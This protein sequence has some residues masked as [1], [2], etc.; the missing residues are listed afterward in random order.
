[1]VEHGGT[2]VESTDTVRGF[3]TIYRSNPVCKEGEL[4]VADWIVPVFSLLGD[5]DAGF[6]SLRLYEFMLAM[7]DEDRQSG[8][9][10]LVKMLVS[11]YVWM[12]C[13][14][15]L[16][17]EFNAQNA[18]L[19][20]DASAGRVWVCVRDMADVFQDL[21]IRA[22]DASV[23]FSRYKAIGTGVSHDLYQRR[24]FAFDF[25]LGTYIL[26][27]LCNEFARLSG[28]SPVTA[29]AMARE[30]CRDL[31]ARYDGYFASDS[32]WWSY[33]KSPNVGRFAYIRERGPQFR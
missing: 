12:S 3:G 26:V 15:G 10:E 32:E 2:Y 24:S 6:E 20:V 16:I 1:M 4:D 9:V 11:T 23:P 29:I 27:P 5:V 18:L 31:L 8:F 25:K 22:T 19:V 17:P 14:L 21:D 7:L 33:P 28:S 30:V 13:D